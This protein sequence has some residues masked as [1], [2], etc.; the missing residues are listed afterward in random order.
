MSRVTVDRE[1]LEKIEGGIKTVEVC[2][3]AGQVVGQFLPQSEYTRMLAECEDPFLLDAGIK[4]RALEDLAAG[5]CKT[6]EQLRE[7][8]ARIRRYFEQYPRSGSSSG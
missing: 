1:W 5:R 2:D 8:F 4:Q 3:A 7:E 6:T